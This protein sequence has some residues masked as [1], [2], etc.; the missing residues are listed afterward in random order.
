MSHWYEA[1]GLS[2]CESLEWPYPVRYGFENEVETDVLVL[3]GG[4]AGVMAAISAAKLGVQVALVEKSHPKSGGGTGVDH[5]LFTPN[6]CSEITPE[7]CAQA[8][9]KS[10]KGYANG[11]SRY[12][13][14]RESYDTLLEIEEMGG[15]IRD[16]EDEFGGAPFRCEK[17][18]YL[19]AYDYTNNIHFRVWGT[20]FKPAI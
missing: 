12:I 19:F 9:V 10:Y 5:W 20:T 2:D 17:T 16:T 6:P 15:K 11:M 13:A 14:S 7:E 4:P 8:E 1:L 18:K 3:G